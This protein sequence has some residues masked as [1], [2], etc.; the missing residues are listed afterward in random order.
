MLGTRSGTSVD[1]QATATAA[2]AHS[3]TIAGANGVSYK[4][5]I[6]YTSA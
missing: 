4:L 6:S 2:G 3:W 5:T 1:V